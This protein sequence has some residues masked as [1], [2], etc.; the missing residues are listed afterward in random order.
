[1]TT[2]Q[3]DIDKIIAQFEKRQCTP[4]LD[5]PTFKTLIQL[6]N[7]LKTNAGSI[8]TTLGGG[9]HGHLGLVVTPDEY[10]KICPN[11][12]FIKPATP[13]PLA[14]TREMNNYDQ[15]RT[16]QDW[17]QQLRLYDLTN[18]V[19]KALIN[20]LSSALPEVYVKIH[21]NPVTNTITDNL[22]QVLKSLF[23]RYGQVTADE[24]EEVESEFARYQHDITQP[25]VVL[26]D[27]IA[28]L[29]EVGELAKIPFSLNQLIS[30]ALRTIRNTGDFETGIKQW[31]TRPPLPP[32]VQL[33]WNMFTDHFDK[34][35]R[36][37]EFIRGNIKKGY[38]YQQANAMKEM[39]E[40]LNGVWDEVFDYI[41]DQQNQ[42]EEVINN[43]STSTIT[44]LQ[45]QLL[46][47]TTRLA[48]V[49][50]AKCTV[51]PT[52]KQSTKSVYTGRKFWTDTGFEYKYCYTH[53]VCKHSSG[54]CPN[55]R[56]DHVAGATFYSCQGGSLRRFHLYKNE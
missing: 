22:H 45:Q 13:G 1:M 16:K 55:P 49:E 33:D 36:E 29:K 26:W 39:Q 15:I 28:Y 37:L 54:E 50:S 8:N 25:L 47:L 56:K 9:A 5:R 18:N 12:P 17:E 51:V 31:Y 44:K 27:K 6:K 43:V 21:R 40:T 10:V 2:T 46:D 14:I 52:T 34:A 53:G 11:T 19:E 48:N 3:T 32:G 30:K 38:M 35:L 42:Y 24:L 7:E 20:Q 23:E 4:I 41:E